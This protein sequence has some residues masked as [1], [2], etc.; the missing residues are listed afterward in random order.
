MAVPRLPYLAPFPPPVIYPASATSLPAAVAAFQRF[1]N[2]D[3]KTSG[4]TLLLTGAGISVESGLADY[5]GKNGTYRLNKKYRPIF[6][7]EFLANH[8]ARKRHVHSSDLDTVQ[9]N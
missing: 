6:Y 8:E 3:I 4:K 7:N 5:R 1:L 2:H 9:G